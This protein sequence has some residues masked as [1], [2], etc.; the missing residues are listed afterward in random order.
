[1]PPK[2]RRVRATN[3]FASSATEKIPCTIDSTQLFDP[4]KEE[5]GVLHSQTIEHKPI[6]SVSSEE[7]QI[8]FYIPAS[9]DEY[10]DVSQTQMRIVCKIVNAV[11][12]SD[13][14]ADDLVSTIQ[15]PIASLFSQVD[16]EVNGKSINSSTKLYPYRA[17]LETVIQSG[18]DERWMVPAG[19]HYSETG[20]SG[21]V[22]SETKPTFHTELAQRFA[23][24]KMVE[25]QGPLFLDFFMQRKMLPPQTP[26]MLRLTRS[27]NSFAL[28]SGMP[29]KTYKMKIIDMSLFMSHVELV[30]ELR[31]ENEKRAL[32]HQMTYPMR[33]VEMRSY[34]I[35]PGQHSHQENYAW[36]GRTP[37][38]LVVALVR[39]EHATGT[40]ST[41]PFTLEHFGLSNIE[42]D[43]NGRKYPAYSVHL[44]HSNPPWSTVGA[45][46]ETMQ[47]L[48]KL[49]GTMS[50][51]SLD[52]WYKD[53]FV[54]AVDL[55]Q[56]LGAESD[57]SVRE[58][59]GQIR[60]ALQFEKVTPVTL[61]L[62]LFI[63][64]NTVLRLDA[65]RN[66]TRDIV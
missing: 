57:C 41:D 13:L 17:L 38:R 12:D 58:E 33:Q 53:K 11:D 23:M 4:V 30:P 22:T 37:R 26:L 27:T 1:M 63:E 5:Q 66:V 6:S 65:G 43:C 20:D 50:G 56:H 3:P 16:L 7:T 32:T 54:Y 46:T 25:L 52:R 55:A 9:S 42:V 29:N 59:K 61:Q 2:R 45:Y 24:S 40:L 28:L 64:F 8:K 39:D 60:I 36:L 18:R 47:G 21:D 31:A 15:L 10:L 62:L 49:S 51:L 44:D 19:Y 14:T 34:M 35:G 48:G